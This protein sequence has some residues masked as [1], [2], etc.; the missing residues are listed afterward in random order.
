MRKSPVQSRLLL[1]AGALLA[2]LVPPAG[3]F[4]ITLT[5]PLVPI[6]VGDS[7]TV[8]VT[9]ADL[10]A[11]NGGDTLLAYG[12]DVET[13]GAAALTAATVAAGF[14]DDA[15]LTGLDVSASAFPGL[16]DTGG[17][18]DLLLSELTLT[19]LV[20]GQ[21]LLTLSA[22]ALNPFQ[23]LVF[24]DGGQFVFSETLTLQIEPAAAPLPGTALLLGAGL[25]ALHRRRRG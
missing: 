12:F 9:A 25:L 22:D 14:L 3:A 11:G 24:A 2:L 15:G 1:A 7:F 16:T 17:S 5:P 8:L 10:F 18:V 13:G 23:G 19:A 20:A 4:Q 6:T 21:L